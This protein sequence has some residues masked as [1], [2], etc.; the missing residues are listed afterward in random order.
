MSAFNPAQDEVA[1]LCRLTLVCSAGDSHPSDAGYAVMGQVV[2]RALA[3]R[4]D[5]P[6][7]PKGEHRG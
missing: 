4:R 5:E 3:A 7:Q 2:W 6:P 1:T